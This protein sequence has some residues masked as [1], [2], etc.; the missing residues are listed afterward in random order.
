[1]VQE[2]NDLGKKTLD[3]FKN[4]K[5]LPTIPKVVIEVNEIKTKGEYKK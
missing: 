5:N 3:E 2:L 4:I 1:M